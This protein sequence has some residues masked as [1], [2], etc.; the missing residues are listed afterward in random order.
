MCKKTLQVQEKDVKFF[1]TEGEDLKKFWQE[2]GGHFN[3]CI[4]N[5]VRQAKK[6]MKLRAAE[7]RET[8]K[9]AKTSYEIAGVYYLDI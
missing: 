4:Q 6:Q 5:K 7:K 1:V 2:Q 9:R 3:F 8:V